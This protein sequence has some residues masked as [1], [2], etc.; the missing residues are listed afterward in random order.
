MK[1]CRAVLGIVLLALLGSAFFVIPVRAQSGNCDYARVWDFA[2]GDYAGWTIQHGT[3]TTNGAEPVYIN[4]TTKLLQMTLMCDEP[5]GNPRKFLYG[6]WSSRGWAGIRPYSLALLDENGDV[7]SGWGNLGQGSGAAGQGWWEYSGNFSAVYGIQIYFQWGTSETYWVNY[8]EIN[9]TTPVG[10][11][12]PVFTPTPVVVPGTGAGWSYPVAQ[13]DRPLSR[14]DLYRVLPVFAEIDLE[15]LTETVPS[16]I[17][18]LSLG[19]GANVHAVLSGQITEIAPLSGMCINQGGIPNIQPG[20]CQMSDPGG[21]ITE[22]L[23]LFYQQAQLVTQDVGEGRFIRYVVASPRVRVG[24]VVEQDCILGQTLPMS[25]GYP[26]LEESQAG[27]TL[28]E[29]LEGEEPFDLLT[30]LSREPDDITCRAEPSPQCS[31]VRNPDFQSAEFWELGAFAGQTPSI[32]LGG[33]L[34]PTGYAVQRDIYLDPETEYAIIVRHIPEPGASSYSFAVELGTDTH[35]IEWIPSDG[36]VPQDI[37]ITAQEY[38]PLTAGGLYDLSISGLANASATTI[39]FICIFDPDAERPQPAGGCLLFNHEFDQD[40][41]SWSSTGVVVWGGG[42]ARVLDEGTI[43]QALRLSPKDSGPQSYTLAVRARRAGVYAEGE[44]IDLGWEWST[45]SGTLAGFTTNQNSNFQEKT[46]TFTVSGAATDDLTL[47]VDADNSTPKSLHIDR[48]C[49]T[50]ND[51]TMPPGYLDPPTIEAN[52][53]ICIYEPSGDI[54]QDLSELVGWLGCML[55]S[56]WECSVKSVLV[57]MWQTLTAILVMFGYFRMWLSLSFMNFAEW[58]NA[59]AVVFAQFLGGELTNVGTR[60]QNSLTS[61]VSITQ[62]QSGNAGIWDVFLALINQ[63]AS[64]IGNVIYG[65]IS[66]LIDLVREIAGGILHLV[67]GMIDLIAA[68]LGVIISLISGFVVNAMGF[69]LGIFQAI[70]NGINMAPA[71][72]PSWLAACSDPLAGAFTPDSQIGYLCLGVY[73]MEQRMQQGAAQYFIPIFVGLASIALLL[74]GA[75]AL[76]NAI[77]SLGGGGGDE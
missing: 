45:F 9:H 32:A 31:Y 76:L 8:F 77:A 75:Q 63:L 54:T 25:K 16:A 26:F 36:V 38:T 55:L 27:W 30:P 2:A 10:T 53:K 4:G 21:G 37:V 5:W 17:L 6:F 19:Q 73:V 74:W 46:A 29:G 52:C 47:T 65:I 60:L 57:G 11:A 39:D 41:V 28:I 71:E 66:P 24:D 51:G 58:A 62:I 15:N 33:G 61:M 34:V 40:S 68:L 13:R 43:S 56:L 22:V 3:Q 7:I 67:A 59:N 64:T 42:L 70:I 14:P 12:T 1:I 20:S 48:V 23:H 49:I 50:T 18:G 35:T 44:T 69:V 72:I